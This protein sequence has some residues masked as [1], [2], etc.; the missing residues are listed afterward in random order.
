VDRPRAAATTAAAVPHVTPVSPALELQIVPP[1]IEQFF[2][3]LPEAASEVTYV[4]VA[5]GAARVGFVE[6]KMRVDESRDV[7][8]MAP[9]TDDVV[10]VDWARATRLDLDTT[11]LERAGVPGARYAPIPD[12]GLKARN[13]ALWEKSFS[14]WL[15][16][17]EK[18]ELL[19]CPVLG[20]TSRPGESERDFR[21]R[22]QEAQRSA[23]DE[24]LAALRKKFAPRQSQ[25]DERLRRAEAAVTRESEQ[26]SHAKIQTAVSMGATLLGVILGRKAVSTGTLGRATTA[27]RGV[28]RSMKEANDIKQA[29]ETVESVR[30]RLH[31]LE[32]EFARETA[33]IAAESD[34][35]LTFETVAIAPKRGQVSIQFVAL[36]WMFPGGRA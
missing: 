24:A 30:D 1:G 34:A 14:R 5:L 13:Y 4:P 8:Y 25:L 32:E 21:I 11:D 29:T 26:A 15:T 23:R 16:Q 19:R 18:L 3:P 6:G 12:A 17:S 28:G 35:P 31:E 2:V 36:G 7:V 22:V 10:A 33:R 9:L 27:A 20:L